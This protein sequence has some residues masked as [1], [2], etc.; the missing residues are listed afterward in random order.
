MNK[1][2]IISIIFI[3]ILFIIIFVFLLKIKNNNHIM[4]RTE[5]SIILIMLNYPE[6][7]KTIY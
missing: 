6:D 2:D 7:D 1:N 4:V 5:K 3:H